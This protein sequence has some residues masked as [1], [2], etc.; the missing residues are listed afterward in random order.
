M[1]RK[2]VF[3]QLCTQSQIRDLQ[4]FENADECEDTSEFN[5]PQRSARVRYLS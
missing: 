5:A 2:C 1:Y 3:R 4:D